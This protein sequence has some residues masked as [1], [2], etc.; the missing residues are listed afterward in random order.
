[1]W[2]P[3]TTST[4]YIKQ[5]LGDSDKALFITDTEQADGKTNQKIST[6]DLAKLH[7]VD[8]TTLILKL[9]NAYLIHVHM[10]CI[11]E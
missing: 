10:Q 11:S 7:P 3:N 5:K 9:H 4:L 6:E 2:T 8:L 1:M